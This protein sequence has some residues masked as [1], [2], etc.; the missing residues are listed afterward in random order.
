MAATPARGADDVRRLFI[1]RLLLLQ[2]LRLWRVC[3]SV[4][5]GGLHRQATARD[6]PP[7]RIRAGAARPPSQHGAPEKRAVA[8]NLVARGRLQPRR[9]EP[10]PLAEACLEH[11]RGFRDVAPQRRAVPVALADL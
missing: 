2:R 1:F 4:L 6:S 5:W 11:L 8:L 10:W 9:R 7:P 3:L